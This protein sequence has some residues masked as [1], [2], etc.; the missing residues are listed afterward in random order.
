MCNKSTDKAVQLEK[1]RQLNFVYQDLSLPEEVRQVAA[2]ER[3]R[4]LIDLG[5]LAKSESNFHDEYQYCDI[6]KD[7][8]NYITIQYN[9]K[10]NQ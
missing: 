2:E 6:Y 3:D 4:I 8:P 1:A 9:I 7:N 5:F 10:L